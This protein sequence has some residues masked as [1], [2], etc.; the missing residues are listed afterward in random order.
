M[1]GVAGPL[2]DDEGFPRGDIDLYAVRQARN[3]YA[4]AQTDHQEVMRKIEEAMPL[5]NLNG[6]CRGLTTCSVL[7]RR[8][9]KGPGRLLVSGNLSDPRDDKSGRASCEP[10]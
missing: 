2:V 10:T 8:V 4:C 5:S 3:K 1:P 9:L 7:W 6:I